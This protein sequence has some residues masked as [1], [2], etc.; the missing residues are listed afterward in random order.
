MSA[1]DMET[2]VA[3]VACKSDV[4]IDR[5]LTHSLDSCGT[6]EDYCGIGNCQEGSCDGGQPYST[7]GNCGVDFEYLPCPPKFGSCCSQYGR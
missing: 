6:G 5:S 4:S 1:V 3:P 7:D 2:A